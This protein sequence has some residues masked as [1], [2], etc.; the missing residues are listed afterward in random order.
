MKYVHV[1]DGTEHE[2]PEGSLNWPWVPEEAA[3][4]AADHQRAR[5]A[6]RGY[7][8]STVASAL[9][10]APAKRGPGRPKAAEADPDA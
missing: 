2:A 6:A 5:A 4:E 7:V 9:E 8:A 1:F 3:E 10:P